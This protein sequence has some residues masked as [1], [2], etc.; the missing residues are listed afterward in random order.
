MCIRDRS[1]TNNVVKSRFIFP[2]LR[3]YQFCHANSALSG[4]ESVKELLF[5]LFRT[6]NGFKFQACIPI[7]GDPFKRSNKL[8]YQPFF[9]SASI[10]IPF[11]EVSD[12]LF[13]IPLTIK[14]VEFR[15]LVAMGHKKDIN[16]FRIRLSTGTQLT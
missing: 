14:L 15:G 1:P 16:P 3:I 7:E 8:L 13:G 11:N 10:A 2:L 4:V 5:Y 6:V 12:V 9:L